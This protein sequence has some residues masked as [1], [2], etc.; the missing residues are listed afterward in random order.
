MN[1]K[2]DKTL[3]SA[4]D[5]IRQDMFDIIKDDRDLEEKHLLLHVFLG[6]VNDLIYEP[7]Y[8]KDTSCKKMAAHYLLEDDRHLEMMD[9]DAQWVRERLER[10]GILEEAR[11]YK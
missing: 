3:I 5:R 1:T 10:Y 9:L 6:A 8:A 4:R 2:A 11:K 7:K